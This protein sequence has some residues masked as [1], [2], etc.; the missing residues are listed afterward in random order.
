MST[1]TGSI[2]FSTYVAQQKG[3]KDKFA[4][5]DVMM[6]EG[7]NKDWQDAI[8]GGVQERIYKAQMKYGPQWERA[9]NSLGTEE[10]R[11][12][13]QWHKTMQGYSANAK[14][15]VDKAKQIC[16]GTFTIRLKIRTG[17]RPT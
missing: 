9:L 1:G 12:L 10:G 11:E 4:W 13:A 3:K 17:R 8:Y 5:E 15:I 16:A 2:P 6:P 7:Y 14:F